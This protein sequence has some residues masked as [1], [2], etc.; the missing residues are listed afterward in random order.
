VSRHR[1]HGCQHQPDY[2]GRGRARA[3]LWRWRLSD[4]LSTRSPI[5]SG[6]NGFHTDSVA[7]QRCVNGSIANAQTLL[8]I[9]SNAGCAA[10]GRGCGTECG[11]QCGG[12][13][14]RGR[15]RGRG[16]GEGSGGHDAS[17]QHHAETSA[18]A[19]A[20]CRLA[21]RKSMRWWQ[22]QP[23]LSGR[24]GNG[25]LTGDFTLTSPRRSQ[26]RWRKSG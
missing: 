8:G 18:R 11:G 9:R 16:C 22:R 20:D 2:P 25:E 23:R 6:I 3:D 14:A 26:R 1:W 5:R 17:D 19:A 4:V 21:G 13:G 10:R 15:R 24:R 7:M 12:D